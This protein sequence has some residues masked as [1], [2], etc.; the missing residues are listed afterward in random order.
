[1][2]VCVSG[3]RSLDS[4]SKQW[5]GRELHLRF[6]RAS[7]VVH[8]LYSTSKWVVLSCGAHILSLTLDSCS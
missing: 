3:P 1:M 2:I 7:D 5:L 6:V 4:L 8:D